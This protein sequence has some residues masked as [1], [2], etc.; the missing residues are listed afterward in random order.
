MRFHFLF[1]A[2]DPLGS[3]ELGVDV[4][5][6]FEPLNVNRI[7]RGGRVPGYLRTN[8][9]R[10]IGVDAG[11]SVAVAW[12]VY[13]IDTKGMSTPGRNEN[14]EDRNGVGIW[15][16]STKSAGSLHPDNGRPRATGNVDESSDYHAVQLHSPF[17]KP[18]LAVKPVVERE[19]LSKYQ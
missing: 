19:Q 1:S 14:I 13:G 16:P 11:G 10:E 17:S 12:C 9:V 7:T 18:P 8:A 4:P 3:R 2:G 5:A 15:I 6:T